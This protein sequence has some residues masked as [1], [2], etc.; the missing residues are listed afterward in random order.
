MKLKQIELTIAKDTVYSSYFVEV[1]Y[2]RNVGRKLK[3]I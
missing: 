1:E 3:T 2:N